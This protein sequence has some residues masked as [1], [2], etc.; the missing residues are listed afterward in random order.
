MKQNDLPLGFCS[1]RDDPPGVLDW[2]IR[3]A[4]LSR[5]GSA[6]N[7]QRMAYGQWPGLPQSD[8]LR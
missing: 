6:M 1:V 3:R 4:T 5:L 2:R 7:W 8:G